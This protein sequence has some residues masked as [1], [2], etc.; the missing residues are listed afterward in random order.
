MNSRFRST[1]S[2]NSGP[3]VSIA[4]SKLTL[5]VIGCVFL[6]CIAEGP[7]LITMDALAGKVSQGLSWY[8]EQASPTTT[9]SLITVVLATSQICAGLWPSKR[10]DRFLMLNLSGK[11]L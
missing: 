3:G 6:F 11:S 9:K 2:T 8:S 10:V 1:V 7:N 5:F 4:V